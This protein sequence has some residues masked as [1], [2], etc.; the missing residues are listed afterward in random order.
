MGNYLY[1]VP[2]KQNPYYMKLTLGNN[3]GGICEVWSRFHHYGK[4]NSKNNLCHKALRFYYPRLT[5]KT[6]ITP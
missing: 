5:S 4:N 6:A 2:G 3:G 1:H